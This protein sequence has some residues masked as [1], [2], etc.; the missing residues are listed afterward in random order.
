MGTSDPA[1]RHRRGARRAEGA[2]ARRLSPRG[3]PAAAHVARR[4]S[5]VSDRLRLRDPQRRLRDRAGRVRQG[6]DNRRRVGLHRPGQP[7]TDES[8]ALDPVPR[9][10]R[11]RFGG[12]EGGSR[13]HAGRALPVPARQA[14]AGARGIPQALAGEPRHRLCRQGAQRRG[15]GAAEQAPSAVRGRFGALDRREGI[16]EN[17]GAGRCA[18]L[19]RARGSRRAS[20]PDPAPGE[21]APGIGRHHHAHAAAGQ[22]GLARNSP[23][24]ESR[25]ADLQRLSARTG[26]AHPTAVFHRPRRSRRAPSA[27]A[28]AGTASAG[29][30]G[31]AA[32]AAAGAA[33]VARTGGTGSAPA[34]GSAPAFHD[35]SS[36]P[37][38]P[39]ATDSAHHVAAPA[40]R[41]SVPR[42]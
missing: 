40:P 18:R 8:A 7:A 19:S 37:D 33:S 17:R 30:T 14:G 36:W 11:S 10:R 13:V 27:G 4:R 3:E 24:R 25:P 35:P 16:S 1:D 2:R 29:A 39:D 9:G 41:D 32:G 20:E 26:A 34:A 5:A 31:A 28:T 21:A 23:E 22:G 12:Q 15:V 42:N 6:P 38:S